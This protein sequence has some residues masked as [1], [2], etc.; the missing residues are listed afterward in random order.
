MRLIIEE[1]RD[2]CH[3]LAREEFLLD[4]CIEGIIYLWRN[5]SSVIVGRHQNTL[6]EVDL[7]F[8][9]SHGI[10]VVRRL[11]GGGAVYHDEGNMN[12]SYIFPGGDFEKHAAEG[13]MML[14]GFLSSMGAVVSASG[15]NDICALKD[16]ELYK[17]SGTAM[18]QRQDRGIFHACLLF[19]ADLDMLGRVLTPPSDKLRSKG[20]SSVRQRTANLKECCPG[21]ETMEADSFFLHMERYF[22]KKLGKEKGERAEN[23]Y[24]SQQIEKL[25][26][27]RYG[28]RQ[29]NFGRDPDTDLENAQRFPVGRV[30]TALKISGGCI[31]ECRFTGDYSDGS[32]LEQIAE[33]L[34]GVMFR[35]DTLRDALEPFDIEKI[36]QTADRSRVTDLLMGRRNKNHD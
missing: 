26:E 10:D 35:E 19:D 6:S 18:T 36:F 2:P 28:N 9:Q 8:A 7:Y 31:E 11:T 25:V 16:G 29:W 30:E 17:I 4:S 1:N 32:G 12:F 23:R 22:A 27:Q 13:E 33:A 15:R 34:K 3:N 24:E 5:S 21:L 14:T 20:I